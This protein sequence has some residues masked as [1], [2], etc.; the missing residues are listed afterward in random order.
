VPGVL[1]SQI[2]PQE[3]PASQAVAEVC[4]LTESRGLTI[5]PLQA[6]LTVTVI[7]NKFPADQK[8]QANNPKQKPILLLRHSTL[9]STTNPFEEKW[10]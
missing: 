3:A 7:Q 4:L 6:L 9:S 5:Q 10:L 8:Y 1:Q 2:Q